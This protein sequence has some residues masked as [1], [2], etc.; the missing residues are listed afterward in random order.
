[1]THSE[2]VTLGHR[3][4]TSRG[5]TAF[6]EFATYDNESPD[7]IGW[8]SGRSILIECKASRG[9]FL[10]DKNKPARRR[11]PELALG[12]QRYYLCPWEMINKNELPERWGLLWAKGDRIYIKVVAIPFAEYNRQGE[13]RFLNSMVRR[14]D[15]R[16]GG[17]HLTDWLRWKNRRMAQ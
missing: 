1:M 17:R 4:L 7:I 9:D 12:R 10:S 8:K 14:A 3:W 16:L 2:L 5:H 6:I 13:L 11:M 15:I